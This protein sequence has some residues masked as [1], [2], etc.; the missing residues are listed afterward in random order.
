MNKRP[1][2]DVSVLAARSYERTQCA[3]GYEG[4][5][6]GSCGRGRDG[7]RYGFYTAFTCTRCKSD[8]LL[9]RGFGGF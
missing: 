3:E 8:G 4:V 2:A 9:V 1:S 7:K 5:L 6:C